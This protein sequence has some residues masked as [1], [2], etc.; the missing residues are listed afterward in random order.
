MAGISKNVN[1]WLHYSCNADI[2]LILEE[3]DNDIVAASN[4][5]KIP[6][7]AFHGVGRVIRDRLEGLSA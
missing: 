2:M 5:Y 4:F 7:Q 3:S 6:T 1:T